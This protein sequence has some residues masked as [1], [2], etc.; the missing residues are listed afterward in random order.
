MLSSMTEVQ[1]RQ[2]VKITEKILQLPIAGSFSRPVDP[3]L[4]GAPGYFDKIKRPMDLSL[5]LRKL[6]DGQY[7][8]IEKWKEDMNL[9]WKNA[10]TYNGANTPIHTVARE[11]SEYFRRKCENIPK[12][13][14]ELWTSRV[15][16]RHA[17]LVKLLEA[18]PDLNPKRT[19]SAEPKMKLY[20]PTKIFLRQKSQNAPEPAKT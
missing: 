13:E 14:V 10:T 7:S 2:C 5:V 6:R 9:I 17:T 15:N 3:E 8:T 20:R 12:S 19:T 11:L 16:K 18:K 4:D 1:H